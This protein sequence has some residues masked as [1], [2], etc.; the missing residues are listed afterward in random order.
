MRVDADEAREVANVVLELDGRITC[1]NGPRRDC[2]AYH[3][4]R[5]DERV[6]ADLN[7]REDRAVRADAR[8]TPD[9]PTLHAVEI[10][11]A[12]PLRIVR[13][14]HVRAEADIVADLRVL[15]DSTGVDV[16]V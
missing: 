14:N 11:G 10:G 1:Q 6:L 8:A 13:E 15:V 5:A 3:A 2:V 16:P 4:P 9:H 7:T 12:L